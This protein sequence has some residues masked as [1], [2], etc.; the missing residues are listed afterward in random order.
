MYLIVDDLGTEGLYVQENYTSY[1]VVLRV[2]FSEPH[3]LE[4]FCFAPLFDPTQVL[5]PLPS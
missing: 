5:H 2:F 3:L 1:N 4:G